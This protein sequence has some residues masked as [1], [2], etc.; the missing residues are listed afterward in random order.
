MGLFPL[1]LP[2]HSPS[3]KEVTAGTKDRNNLETETGVDAVEECCLLACSTL[4]AQP[5]FLE[6]NPRP[7]DQLKPGLLYNSGA[8]CPEVAL[9][10]VVRQLPHQ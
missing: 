5:A 4:F 10:K 3:L 9:S 2:R 6:D 1:K 8:T 7:E